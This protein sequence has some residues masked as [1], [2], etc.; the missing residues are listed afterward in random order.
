MNEEQK[1]REMQ[2]EE[3]AQIICGRSKDDI[4]LIDK[5]S[6]DSSCRWARDAEALYNAGYQKI[7]LFAECR[8]CTA[9]SGTDCTRH[10]Y[11]QG[12]LKDENNIKRQAVKEFAR[13]LKELLH[14]DYIMPNGSTDEK[15]VFECIDELL[16][17]Y[18]E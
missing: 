4:C 12:C 6:C 7:D 1:R 15:H 13:K 14:S 8:N 9:W 16:K 3:M 18:E 11:T 10:P 17:E 5:T 2:I